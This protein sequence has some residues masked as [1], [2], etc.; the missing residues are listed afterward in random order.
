M[1]PTPT[2]SDRPHAPGG[3][4]VVRDKMRE[5]VQLADLKPGVN[6]ELL[7]PRSEGAGDA[8]R[9]SGETRSIF[10]NQFANQGVDLKQPFAVTYDGYFRAPTDGVYEIQVDSTWDVT[11]VLGGGRLLRPHPDRQRQHP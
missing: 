1:T 9:K 4:T 10:L 6:Y 7:I 2:M 8:S 3:A 11:V 5:P